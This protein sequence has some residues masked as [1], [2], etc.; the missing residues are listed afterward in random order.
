MR[1]CQK[2]QKLYMETKVLKWTSGVQVGGSRF[3]SGI[4]VGFSQKK[5]RSPS[6]E[7]SNLLG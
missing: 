6:A 2:Y 7:S 1:A 4:E 3:I 5:A